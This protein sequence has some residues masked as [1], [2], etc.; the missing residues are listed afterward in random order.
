MKKN[1]NNILAGYKNILIYNKNI[2]MHQEINMYH[3]AITDPEIVLSLASGNQEIKPAKNNKMENILNEIFQES[4]KHKMNLVLDEMIEVYNKHKMNLVLNEMIE[5]SNKHKMNSI[6]N[7]RNDV[8]QEIQNINFM[9]KQK[10]ILNNSKIENPSL[11]DILDGLQK[12]YNNRIYERNNNN[13]FCIGTIC[14]LA[15]LITY[16]YFI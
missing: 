3:K 16:I 7:K 11:L 15:F 10:F 5:V 2:R 6:F 1:L 9:E 12:I 4:N 8:I 14:I 13:Y